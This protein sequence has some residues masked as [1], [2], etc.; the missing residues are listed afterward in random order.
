MCRPSVATLPEHVT[1]KGTARGLIPTVLAQRTPQD[2]TALPPEHTSKTYKV[3]DDLRGAKQRPLSS[4]TVPSTI[5]SGRGATCGG[6]R[7]PGELEH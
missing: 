4:T 1:G 2:L 6:R 3:Q 7:R 5:D